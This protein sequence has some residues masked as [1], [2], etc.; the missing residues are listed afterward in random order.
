VS[1]KK[2]RDRKEPNTPSAGLDAWGDDQPPLTG[3]RVLLA[4]ALS[5]FAFSFALRA[6]H[7]LDVRAAYPFFHYIVGDAAAYNDWARRIAGGE[8]IGKKIFYQDPLYP[9]LLGLFYRLAGYHPGA[10][11][12]LQIG[13]GSLTCVL[14]YDT[15]R[16]LWNNAVGLIAGGLSGAY[17]LFIFYEGTL[18]KEPAGVFFATALVWLLVIA[19]GRAW[20]RAR[21]ALTFL[22]A[23]I[24]LGLLAL[25]RGNAL[26]LVPAVLAWIWIITKDQ[27][28]GIKFAGWNA[29]W[30]LLG[31][32]LALAPATLHNAIAEHEFVLTTGQAG[33]N[34]YIGNNARATGLYEPLVAAHQTS[35]YEGDDARRI[36]EF[37]CR[38]KL[39]PGEVSRWWF[40]RTWSDI[41]R[42]PGGWLD[43]LLRK[44]ALFTQA[45]E[46][47]DYEDVY[48]ARRYSRILRLPLFN[49]GVV[50]PLA[51]FGMALTLRQWKRFLVPAGMILIGSASIILFYLMA[52]YR[53]FVLP[54]F[55]LFAAGAIFKIIGWARAKKGGKLAGAALA[56]GV[57]I[58]MGHRYDRILTKATSSSLTNLGI[59]Y[60]DN[61]EP[62]K[63]R[64][65]MN[66]ALDLSPDDPEVT[67]DIGNLYYKVKDLPN[68]IA[69]YEK[70]LLLNPRHSE[71][72]YQLGTIYFYRNELDKAREE[73][74]NVLKIVPTHEDALNGLQVIR[75][76]RASARR[77]S[78][79]RAPAL[80]ANPGIPPDILEK[81]RQQMEQ[82]EKK[83]GAP[84]RP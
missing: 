64:E 69:T 21:T 29:G 23:G 70:V 26:L 55:I 80:P 9:Y 39:T 18:L 56:L 67:Y 47:P 61:G 27:Q 30:F 54:A 57:L 45:Y 66:A 2:H 16:R 17:N 10:V 72:M 77:A 68:A 25:T 49:F 42:D 76:K 33:P 19:Q 4:S 58:W 37:K 15:A 81:L 59:Y 52:R 20:R 73:W 31:C 46:I 13:A 1:K 8:W 48:V 6:L 38:R 41:A 83:D 36:A 79:R 40:A 7:L 11:R 60:Q 75:E 5:V 50:F 28:L 34:F 53:L 32:F 65:M 82:K 22:G 14:L 63:A 3:W 71:A 44:A 35:E 74:E 84:P 51:I 24:V 78:P 12:W 43:L 62:G